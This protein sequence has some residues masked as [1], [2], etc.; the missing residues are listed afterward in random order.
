VLD[1]YEPGCRTVQSMTRPSVEVD[2]IDDNKPA[3]TI[4]TWH[5]LYILVDKIVALG[6]A[7]CF[8]CPGVHEI[9]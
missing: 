1:C 7:C 5:D 4:N 6:G 2:M 9:V 3:I 8:A